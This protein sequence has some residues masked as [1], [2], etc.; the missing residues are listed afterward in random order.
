MSY[1]IISF[2]MKTYLRFDDTF[3]QIDSAYNS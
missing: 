2:D 1:E 3:V